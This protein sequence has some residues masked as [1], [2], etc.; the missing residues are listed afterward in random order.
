MA[1]SVNLLTKRNTTDPMRGTLCAAKKRHDGSMT[2]EAWRKQKWRHD[3]GM[4]E[5]WPYLAWWA[6]IDPRGMTEAWRKHDGTRLGPGL[7][8]SRHSGED[9]D[10]PFEVQIVQIS[11][12]LMIYPMR[13]P[14]VQWISS[15]A[16]IFLH[17]MRGP[18]VQW[19][20]SHSGVWRC[21]LKR[22]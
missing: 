15:H 5:A 8:L 6:R 4:T 7:L 17:T 9:A 3:G 11:L 14:Y 19:I 12:I 10:T 21:F 13:G 1:P 18:Y 2:E 22:F 16:G 20:S